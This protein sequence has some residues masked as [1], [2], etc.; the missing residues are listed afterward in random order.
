[1]KALKK[2]QF[3]VFMAIVA[4]TSVMLTSCKK[5]EPL[6]LTAVINV[7]STTGNKSGDIKG[8]GGSATKTFTF[9]NPNTTAGWDMSISAKSGSFKLVL[10]DASGSIVLDKTLTAGSGLQ[11]ADGTT[12]AGTSGIWSATVTL[13]NFNGTG[14]YSFR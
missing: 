3:L 8:D 10:K 5:D 9:T 7:S 11:S 4:L 14:D 13:T 6:P 1:M 2:I 12:P